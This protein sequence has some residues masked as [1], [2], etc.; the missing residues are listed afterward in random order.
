MT[1][2]YFRRPEPGH[3]REVSDILMAANLAVETRVAQCPGVEDVAEGLDLTEVAGVIGKD[4]HLCAAIGKLEPVGDSFL[5][6]EPL[7]EGEVGFVVLGAVLTNGIGPRQP[8]IDGPRKC[9]EPLVEHLFEDLGDRLLLEDAGVDSVTESLE[10]RHDIETSR[11]TLRVRAPFL[12]TRDDTRDD[13]LRFPP[14]QD[15][16]AGLPQQQSGLRIEVVGLKV[17]PK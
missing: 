12:D 7:A 6:H 2:D 4:E 17:E 3:D 5:F 16:L 13:S 14:L 15:E 1:R 10:S 8:R 9:R 11:Y